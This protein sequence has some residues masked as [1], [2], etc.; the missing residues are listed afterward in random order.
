MRWHHFSFFQIV[1]GFELWF[2]VLFIN[3]LIFFSFRRLVFKFRLLFTSSF[4]VG[5][6][7]VRYWGNWAFLVFGQTLIF[8]IEFGI[9]FGVGFDWGLGV[10]CDNCGL[11]FFFLFIWWGQ[12]KFV[13]NFFKWS[14]SYV[15]VAHFWFEWRHLWYLKCRH[16]ELRFS[17]LTLFGR[18][19]FLLCIRF[20]SL[21]LFSSPLLFLC[22]LLC[23]I[24]SEGFSFKLGLF[25]LSL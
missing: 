22:S 20:Y 17:F 12:H 24:F 1:V 9:G 14:F 3:L 7:F 4:L 25:L 8:W 2:F 16:I 21:C 10:I 13:Y 15:L 19:R 11:A 5:A 23:F 18:R 6:L